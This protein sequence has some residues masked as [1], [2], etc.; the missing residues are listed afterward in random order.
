MYIIAQIW[1]QPMYLKNRRDKYIAIQEIYTE[2]VVFKLLLHVFVWINLTCYI[3]HMAKKHQ[4]HDSMNIK[5][6]NLKK[7]L[8]G[9]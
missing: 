4:K 2:I 6:N 8:L 7:K 3:I 1:K 5:L 9:W